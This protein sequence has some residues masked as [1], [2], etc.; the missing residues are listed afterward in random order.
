MGQ[1]SRIVGPVMTSGGTLS[2]ESPLTSSRTYIE[3]LLD[4]PERDL[5]LPCTCVRCKA[6]S[7]SFLLSTIAVAMSTSNSTET[8]LANTSQSPPTP[9]TVVS[10][11][12]A[13]WVLVSPIS[14]LGK[15]KTHSLMSPL[16]V[17]DPHCTAPRGRPLDL[18]RLSQSTSTSRDLRSSTGDGDT[19][20]PVESAWRGSRR[21]GHLSDVH[22]VLCSTSETASGNN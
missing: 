13:A 18:P 6:H 11:A 9:T 21:L 3:A 4:V 22:L 19:T 2:L 5:V 20:A 17:G 15:Y 12:V 14:N 16:P 1:M 8:Q 7:R 10:P